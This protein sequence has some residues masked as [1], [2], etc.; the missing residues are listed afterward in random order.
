MVSL[1]FAAFR[2]FD[3]NKFMNKEQIVG[4]SSLPDLQDLQKIKRKSLQ[5]TARVA[6]Y[7]NVPIAIPRISSW[8]KT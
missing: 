4:V 2:L 3:I 6:D 8:P 1:R 5:H 7:K